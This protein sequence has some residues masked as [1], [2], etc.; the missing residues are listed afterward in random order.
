VIVLGAC[1]ATPHPGSRLE[2]QKSSDLAPS[3]QEARRDCKVQ[4]AADTLGM[5]QG[6]AVIGGDFVKCMRA[7]G[8]TLLDRGAE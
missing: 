6:T 1:A 2:W 4:A 5:P 7:A 3:L 8:W